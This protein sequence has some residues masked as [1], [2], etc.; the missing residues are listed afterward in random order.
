VLPEHWSI[1]DTSTGT[2][3]RP[4]GS[5]LSNLVEARLNQPQFA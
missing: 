3:V 5:A 4:V 2:N 1:D